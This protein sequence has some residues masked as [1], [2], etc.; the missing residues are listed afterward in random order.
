MRELKISMTVQQDDLEKLDDFLSK[1]MNILLLLTLKIL[2]P[3]K[4]IQ[5]VELNFGKFLDLNALVLLHLMPLTRL[6]EYILFLVDV[7]IVV[8]IELKVLVTLKLKA[9]AIEEI[10]ALKMDKL[11]ILVTVQRKHGQVNLSISLLPRFFVRAP[12][13]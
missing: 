11:K 3:V 7:K 6:N 2:M 10:R 13:K 8:P 4:K 5:L 9:L 1:Q 12:E